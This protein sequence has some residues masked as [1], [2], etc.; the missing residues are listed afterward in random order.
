M[1]ENPSYM[2]TITT[3]FTNGEKGPEIM[4]P[5]MED[6]KRLFDLYCKVFKKQSKGLKILKILSC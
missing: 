4:A 1:Y 2:I 3:F 6:A 5:N